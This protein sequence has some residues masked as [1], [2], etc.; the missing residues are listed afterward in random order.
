MHDLLESVVQHEIKLVL[1]Y[2]M[3]DRQMLDRQPLI[4]LNQLS[5]EIT[6]D[7][8]TTET[9]NK[10]SEIKLHSQGNAIGQRP[11]NLGT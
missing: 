11:Y 10:P 7:Y 5:R 9:S 6:F 8:G 2:L 4:T 1:S 3:L